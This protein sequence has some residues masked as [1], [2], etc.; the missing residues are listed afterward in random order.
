MANHRKNHISLVFQNY[1]LID[2][3]TSVENVKLGGNAD[4][5]ILLTQMGIDKSTGK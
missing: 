5:E 4:A 3:L 2:Y 1:N